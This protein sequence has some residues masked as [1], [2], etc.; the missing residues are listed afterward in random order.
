[1][2]RARILRVAAGPNEIVQHEDL[3]ARL[4]SLVCRLD[5]RERTIIGLRFGL[6]G[7]RPRT[8][9]SVSEA[10]QRTSERVRQI[11]ARA[12]AKLRVMMR[13]EEVV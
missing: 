11:Q 1:M 12:I 6:D 5:E 13:A 2:H 4:R 7:K 8:L 10:M 3:I 9:P